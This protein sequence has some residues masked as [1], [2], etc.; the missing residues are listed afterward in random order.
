[1]SGDYD[2]GMLVLC[3]N[4]H[5]KEAS[6]SRRLA[7]TLFGRHQVFEHLGARL[8]ISFFRELPY[9]VTIREAA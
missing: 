4:L 6:W 5:W 9:L 1:M 7:A 2:I 8:R 3:A